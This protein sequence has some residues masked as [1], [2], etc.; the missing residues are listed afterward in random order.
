VSH[1]APAAQDQACILSPRCDGG[2][3]SNA[4]GRQLVSGF[5]KLDRNYLHAVQLERGL[6]RWGARPGPLSRVASVPK[7]HRHRAEATG[8]CRSGTTSDAIS[9]SRWKMQTAASARA[10][11]RTPVLTTAPK[12]LEARR[13]HLGI[14]EA[15]NPMI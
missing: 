12:A 11:L 5:W 8:R 3:T 2:A 15:R 6:Y 10:W 1:A 13:S 9:G 7:Q 14:D 4:P